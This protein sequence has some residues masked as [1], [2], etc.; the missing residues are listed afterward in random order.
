[1]VSP[2]FQPSRA[3]SRR[4]AADHATITNTILNSRS[5]AK[6]AVTLPA[7]TPSTIVTHH[8]LRMSMSTAPR[9]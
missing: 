5:G 2:N 3:S 9:L 4:V 8:N 1:M 6:R 7:T